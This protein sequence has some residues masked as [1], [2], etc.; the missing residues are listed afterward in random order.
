[1]EWEVVLGSVAGLTHIVAFGIYNLQMFRGQSIP[2]SSTWTLWTFL[3]TLNCLTYLSASGDW[4][5][6]LLPIA[7]SLACIATFFIALKK[8]KLSKLDQVEKI[9]LGLGI[10]SA[11]VWFALHS[12]AKANLILQVCIVISFIAT[13]RSVWRKPDSE[14]ALPWFIW[15][16]AYV[17]SITVVIWRWQSQWIDL[18]YPVN[19]LF[20]HAIV[21]LLAF[22]R[23]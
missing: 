5:K 14:K 1:M 4:V 16:S 22:R 13:F 15:S 11:V 21:G 3:S 23:A 17:L 20:L 10:L 19:C 12:A 8:G 9:L 18:A 2:N 7:S 6:A